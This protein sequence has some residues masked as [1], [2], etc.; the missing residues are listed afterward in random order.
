MRKLMLNCEHSTSEQITRK[1]FRN[2]RQRIV[3]KTL[4]QN[5]CYC[6]KKIGTVGKTQCSLAEQIKNQQHNPNKFQTIINFIS[7]HLP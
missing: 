4:H 2:V 3:N 7:R 5:L 6:L 1:N